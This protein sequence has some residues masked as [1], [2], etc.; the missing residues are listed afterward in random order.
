MKR[1]QSG[2]CADAVQVIVALKHLLS[3]HGLN[4]VAERRVINIDGV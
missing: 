4:N 2:Y 3:A 1:R